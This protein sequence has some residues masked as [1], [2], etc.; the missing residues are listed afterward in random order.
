MRPIDFCTPKH[1]QLEHPCSVASQRSAPDLR[2]A[3]RRP[4]RA[5]SRSEPCGSCSFTRKVFFRAPLSPSEDARGR[6]REARGRPMRTRPGRIAFHGATPTAA[7]CRCAYAM[8]F[9]SAARARTPASGIPVASSELVSV[10]R[11]LRSS[12]LWLEGRQDRFRGGLVKGVRF[13]DPRCLPPVGASHNPPAPKCERTP[14]AFT[15]RPALT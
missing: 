5:R 10:V 8:A 4:R 7:G 15:N 12:A 11:D 9:S 13:P 3:F 1:F 2:E 6:H 14:E